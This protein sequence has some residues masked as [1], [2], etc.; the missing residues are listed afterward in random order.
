LEI[1]HRWWWRYRDWI[2]RVKMNMKIIFKKLIWIIATILILILIGNTV[3]YFWLSSSSAFKE[4]KKTFYS[5]KDFEIRAI[6][7]Y[8]TEEIRLVYFSTNKYLYLEDKSVLS[9]T[10][11]IGCDHYQVQMTK[12]KNEKWRITKFEEANK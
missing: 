1:Q 10:V 9:F 4:F 12:V 8:S 11:S 2:K 5:Q 3:F 6:K 7:N